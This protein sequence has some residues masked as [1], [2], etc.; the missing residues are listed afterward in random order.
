V[1]KP[2]LRVVADLGSSFSIVAKFLLFAYQR[3][4]QFLLTLSLKPIG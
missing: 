1:R 4:D 3:E 2:L